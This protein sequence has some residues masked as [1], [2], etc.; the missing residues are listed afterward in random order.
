MN[1]EESLEEYG[2]ANNNRLS[3]SSVKR[4]LDIYGIK[5]IKSM[6]QNFLIDGNITEKIVRLSGIDDSCAVLEIGPGLGALTLELSRVAGHVIAIELDRRLLPILNDTLSECGN[7]VVIQGDVLKLDVNDIISDICDGLSYHVCANLPYNITTPMLTKLIS[8]DVFDTIT[9]M[10][11]K[12]VAHR[13]CADPGTSEYGAFTIYVNYYSVPHLLFDVSPECFLPRPNVRS[14]VISLVKRESRLLDPFRESVFFRIVRASFAQRRKTLVN[15]LFAVFGDVATKDALSRL[16]S[17]A[18]F[19]VLIRG[20]T[21]SINDF[22]CLTDS[23]LSH[24][25]I[26]TPSD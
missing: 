10:L 18:G 16:V 5:S 26:E 9:V 12:E 25:L 2:L 11:Q 19:D 22:K 21:L 17:D 13:I 6:G 8:S 1:M 15:S 3:V 20:E 23:F 4:L 24:G 7:V 14:S